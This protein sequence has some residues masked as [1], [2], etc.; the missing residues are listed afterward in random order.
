MFKGFRHWFR[1]GNLKEIKIKQSDLSVDYVG[2]SEILKSKLIDV[3]ENVDTFIHC[4]T[5]S[6]MA[7]MVDI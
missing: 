1:H 4:W 5:P 2:I 3:N 6:V 7:N